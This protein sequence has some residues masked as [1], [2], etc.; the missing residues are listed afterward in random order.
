MCVSIYWVNKNYEIFEEPIVLVQ[1]PKMD[2]ATILAAIKDVLLC[3][4]C[5]LVC[6]GDKHI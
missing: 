2:A 6:A 4:V 5:Q 3:C 1:I